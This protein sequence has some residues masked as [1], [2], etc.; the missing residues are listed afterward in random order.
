M[1]NKEILVT[2]KNK[3]TSNINVPEFINWL[4][5]MFDKGKKKS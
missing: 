5:L 1:F 3:Q 4:F 2:L